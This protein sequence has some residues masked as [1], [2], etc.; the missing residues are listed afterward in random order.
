VRPIVNPEDFYVPALATIYQCFCDMGARGEAIDV[1]TASSELRAIERLNTVGGAQF[2]GELTD[3]IP[4]IAHVESHA[5]I[6]A[7]FGVARRIITASMATVTDGFQ[8]GP[9][10]EFIDRTLLRLSEAA[11][12][13]DQGQ[14]VTLEDAVIESFAR[15]E[16]A[17]VGGQRIL[18]VPTG[19][20]DFDALTAGMHGG[21]LLIIAARPAMGKTSLVLNLSTHAA[22]AT[23]RPV[24]FFSLEMPRVELTNRLLCAEAR[25]DLLRLRTRPATT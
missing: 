9:V 24:L 11:K 22:A 4:T 14:T 12:R 17:L 2:L 23:G 10:D 13:P 5:R 3:E 15:I 8:G 16:S 21:Q 25:V 1:V 6:V 19:F 18:G 20:R 7:D